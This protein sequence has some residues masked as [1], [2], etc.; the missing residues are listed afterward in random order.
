MPV[1]PDPGFEAGGARVVVSGASRRLERLVVDRLALERE[2]ER[3]VRLPVDLLLFSYDAI[4]P[5]R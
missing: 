3:G 2:D 1:S 5:A 4:Y